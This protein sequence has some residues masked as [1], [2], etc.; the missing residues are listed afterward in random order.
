MK[1]VA[2]A[3]KVDAVPSVSAN[4]L[5]TIVYQYSCHTS[6][7]K[8][9]ALLSPFSRTASESTKPRKSVKGLFKK[10]LKSVEKLSS[11]S[12]KVIKHAEEENELVDDQK[13]ESQDV[14]KS[15][16]CTAGITHIAN[17][18]CHW[19]PGMSLVLDL[20]RCYLYLLK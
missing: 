20:H 1:T 17:I 10:Q 7:P 13:S 11:A 15:L 5:G 12:S 9:Q 4:D 2:D 8:W 19:K 6:D 16:Q 14:A 3:G 18:T